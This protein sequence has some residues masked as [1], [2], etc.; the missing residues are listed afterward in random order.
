MSMA[1][2]I[3]SKKRPFFNFFFP[4]ILYDFIIL[5][6]YKKTQLLRKIKIYKVFEKIKNKIE[7]ELELLYEKE[8]YR[9]KEKWVRRE[10]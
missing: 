5:H 2:T 1:I 7:I 4:H 8:M 3:Q 6:I 9:M 10:G